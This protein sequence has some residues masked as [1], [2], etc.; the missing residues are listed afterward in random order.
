MRKIF[1]QFTLLIALVF[2]LSNYAYPC[3]CLQVSHKKEIKN[4]ELIFS[5]LVTDVVEDKSYVAE[6][7]NPGK[8]FFATLKV[9]KIFKGNV[10]NEFT[11]YRYDM[12][13]KFSCVG[14]EF[15]NGIR[16]LIYASNSKYKREYYLDTGVCSRTKIL[17][18]NSKEYK[19]LLKI[20]VKKQK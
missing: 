1:F 19:E 8:R 16:Y 14:I 11:I 5:A 10:A 4:T 13:R 3:S 12:E 15:S 7:S 9:E 2:C 6:K 18:E 20:R 17:N